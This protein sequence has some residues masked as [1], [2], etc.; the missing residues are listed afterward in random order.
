MANKASVV[1]RIANNTSTSQAE[2]SRW[3]DAIV[4][5]MFEELASGREISLPKFGKLTP[6]QREARAGRNPA[7]GDTVEIPAK[8][9]VKFK[10]S[11]TLKAAVADVAVT[12]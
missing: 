4:D 2:A 6:V 11:S 9:V 1:Q 10:A 3:F 8:T 12:A 7:T 5:A